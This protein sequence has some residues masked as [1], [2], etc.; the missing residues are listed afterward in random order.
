MA[1]VTDTTAQER[2]EKENAAALLRNEPP[3]TVSSVPI[4]S[5]KERGN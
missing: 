3:I 4:D 5:P 1:T 2:W